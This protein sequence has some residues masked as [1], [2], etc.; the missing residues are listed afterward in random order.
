MNTKIVW[1]G[2]SKT[3]ISPHYNYIFNYDNGFFCRWGKT[4]EDNP[5]YSPFGN[6][7]LDI[8]VSTICSRAC[9]WCYKSNN[10]VGTNMSFDTFK[11]ILDKMPPTLTQIA[12]GIGDVGAN[13]DLWKMMDHCRS[14]KVVPNI[15]I[16]GDGVSSDEYDKL[17]KYCGAVSVSLYEKDTCYNAVK[18]LTD[19]GM[20]QVNIH[21]ILSQE[22]Y[23]TCYSAVYDKTLDNRLAKLNAV[24]FLWL[25]PIG[26]R[27]K[28]H[29]LDSM[30]EL[31]GLINIAL[32]TGHKFGFDS[33][34]APN[35]LRAV[36]DNE[37]F[38]LYKTMSESCESS[39]FSYYINVDGIGFPCS[40]AENIC[41]GVDV[42]TCDDFWNHPNTVAFRKKLL[43]VEDCNGCHACQLYDLEVIEG[44]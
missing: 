14:K 31:K 30:S 15:T 19:R 38:E 9:P 36:K 22:T 26:K 34:T 33:C 11:K 13:P 16:H 24:I 21:V 42:L 43:R 4:V 39:L 37:S 44:E 41:E 3:F 20:D 35:F 25:K 1:E 12:F 17:A 32:R 6:E 8:E 18:E 23:K 40:F 5:Q 28:L 27:N 2:S 7:I 10:S 29:Q